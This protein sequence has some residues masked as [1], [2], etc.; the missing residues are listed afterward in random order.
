MANQVHK[1][2][3]ILNDRHIAGQFNPDERTETCRYRLSYIARY[4]TDDEPEYAIWLVKH[5]TVITDTPEGYLDEGQYYEHQLPKWVQERIAILSLL[6]S[7]TP[8]SAILGVGR[9]IS[10][11]IF[12][13]Q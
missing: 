10:E 5:L 11:H 2:I 9:R 6:P 7:R 4:K 1:S 12:W 13:V 8:T 3:L